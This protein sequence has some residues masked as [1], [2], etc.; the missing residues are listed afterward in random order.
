MQD[1]YLFALPSELFLKSSRSSATCQMGLFLSSMTP[2]SFSW[3]RVRTWKQWIVF[4]SGSTRIRKTLHSTTGD[5]Y[6]QF[7]TWSR[8]HCLK[9]LFF[10]HSIAWTCS[11]II[12]LETIE[13]DG[14]HF[15]RAERRSKRGHHYFASSVILS[16]WKERRK[17]D[18]DQNPGPR[19]LSSQALPLQLPM[20]PLRWSLINWVGSIAQMSC[21]SPSSPGFDSRHT[22]KIFCCWRL[23]LF[24]ESGQR[25]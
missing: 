5:L 11:V 3:A 17:T 14:G 23:T 7:E 15:E 22:P 16:E 6:Q 12:T 8:E 10:Q 20:L 13:I 2:N 4:N 18:W 9:L 21:L 24:M 1:I 25:L 19:H